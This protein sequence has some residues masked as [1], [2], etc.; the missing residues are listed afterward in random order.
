[1]MDK[2]VYKNN[3]IISL[4]ILIK[5][6]FHIHKIANLY[7]PEAFVVPENIMFF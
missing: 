2:N 3:I 6:F 7:V 5:F 4:K 1:M